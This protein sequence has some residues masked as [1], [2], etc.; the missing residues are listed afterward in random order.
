MSPTLTGTPAA[1]AGVPPTQ[2]YDTFN[3][4]GPVWV[5]GA[6]YMS[7][8]A[9][10][11]NPPSGRIVKYTPG[12]TAQVWLDNVGTNGLAIDPDGALYGAVHEDGSISRFDLNNP[13][14]ARVPVVTGYMDTRF[15]SPND[16]TF[17]SDGVLYF[18]DP[19]YQA[20]A[21]PPQP[22]RAYWYDPGNSSVHVIQGAPTEPNGIAL[23]P[24]QKTLYIAGSSPLMAFP[25]NP[26]GSLGTGTQFGDQQYRGIDGMGVDCA[27]NL[28]LAAYQQ[29]DVVVLSPSGAE[30]GRLNVAVGVTNIAFGGADRTTLYITNLE[31]KQLYE[32]NMGI[33]GYPY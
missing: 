18:T 20:P 13:N 29:G 28:Y 22:P 16:L 14:A 11:E 8:M 25:V 24:D 10:E 32:V 12:G 3:V 26:D 15:S 5:G 30:L 21:P 17:R 2:D 33:V 23:S 1:V 31:T 27:G 19:D 6:L 7:Q 4:E 9:N